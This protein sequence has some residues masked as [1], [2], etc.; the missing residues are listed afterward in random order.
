[1]EDLFVQVTR[2]AEGKKPRLNAREWSE[3]LQHMLDLRRLIPIVPIHLCLEILCE[4]L[5]CSEVDENINLVRDMFEYR[6]ADA[7]FKTKIAMLF[8]MSRHKL[9][10]LSLESK[11]K[12]V[13]KAC[14]YYLDSSKD[15]DDPNLELA[16]RCLELVKEDSPVLQKYH[17]I[18]NGLK[19]MHEF[20]VSILPL[21]LR[22]MTNYQPIVHK[23][24]QVDPSAYKNVRKILR[25]FK[26]LNGNGHAN[27]E[28]P[29]LS[30]IASYA[31]K[32]EDFDYCLSICDLMMEKP[33]QEACKVCLNLINAQN[34]VDWTAKA[35]LTSFCVN[36]C[37]DEAIEEMLMQRI[38]LSQ[39][40]D[41]D[42]TMQQQG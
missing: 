3:V 4:S 16:H 14:E 31:L 33:S 20:G 9:G 41:M 35:R 8:V 22:N 7:L 13:G 11:E 29:L 34:F 19:T 1:M 24:L 38:N 17:G 6:P 32:A 23:I 27:A 37:E 15:V 5:L 10:N 39:E 18:L 36:Y 40:E 21:V 12:I 28:A 42:T 25:M 30:I 2:R 26:L